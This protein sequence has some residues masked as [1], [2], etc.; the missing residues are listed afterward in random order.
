MTKSVVFSINGELQSPPDSELDSE[1]IEYLH[2]DK[3]LTATK[4]CCGIGVCRACTVAVERSKNAPLE[5]MLACSTPISELNGVNILTVEG[6]AQNGGL[7]PLQTAFLEHFSFQCGY[8]TSGFLMA[9][10]AALSRI[11]DLGITSMS[12]KSAEAVDQILQEF[13]GPHICRC[14]G[15]TKYYAAFKALIEEQLGIKFTS[16]TPINNSLFQEA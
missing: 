16:A 4:F 13:I 7:H 3:N 15:Y 6:L 5:V 12:S 11:R 10:I 1:L 14:T 2:E 8:C 9:G